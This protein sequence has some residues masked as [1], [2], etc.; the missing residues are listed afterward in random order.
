M[1]TAF[2][3]VNIDCLDEFFVIDFSVPASATRDSNLSA[4]SDTGASALEKAMQLLHLLFTSFHFEKSAFQRAKEQITSET[5]AYSRDLVGYSLGELIVSMSSSDP[6]FKALKPDVLDRIDFNTVETLMRS[7]LEHQLFRGSFE[8]MIVGDIDT[9]HATRLA[10]VYLGTIRPQS[11]PPSAAAH[12]N[13]QDISP[14]SK[15]QQD[16]PA[17]DVDTLLRP[18]Q[19]S[20]YQEESSAEWGAS[21]GW[22]LL[23]GRRLYVYVKDSDERAVVHIGGFAPNR[24]GIYPDG[25]LL[26]D[27]IGASDRQFGTLRNCVEGSAVRANSCSKLLKAPDSQYRRHPAFPRIALWVLQELVTKR[28]FTVLREE[29]RLTYEASFEFLGFEILW[30]GVFVVTVHTQPHQI[31]HV[32]DATL[33]ALQQLKSSRPLTESQLS[34]AKQ[35]V[36][37]RHVHDS[38]FAR[39]WLDL[40]GGIQLSEV[41]FGFGGCRV[42]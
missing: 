9:A 18:R 27:K 28:L 1:Q 13:I 25:T 24:W 4:E 19:S 5:Q 39:Y 36:L 35:Q 6:R 22:K 34:G 3:G 11:T 12:F 17:R 37:G 23:S 16:I 8:V 33:E 10:Q 40:L 15:K 2:L 31:E 20:N 7:Y 42:P 32:V 29:K 38:K 30:G 41:W 14:Y 26:C 21:G